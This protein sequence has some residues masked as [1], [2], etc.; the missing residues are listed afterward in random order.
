MFPQSYQIICNFTIIKYMSKYMLRSHLQGPIIRHFNL[1]ADKR[2]WRNNSRLSTRIQ[3][4][5]FPNGNLHLEI[6]EQSKNGVGC[7]YF[8]SFLGY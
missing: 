8:F 6:V 7:L 2:G 4:H 3:P 1:S 5:T